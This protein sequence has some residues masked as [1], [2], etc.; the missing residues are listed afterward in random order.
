MNLDTQPLEEIARQIIDL[1]TAE[2]LVLTLPTTLDDTTAARLRA[3]LIGLVPE[4][5]RKGK[6][7][8]VLAHGM[9]LSSI[10]AEQLKALGYQRVQP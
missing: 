4:E 6:A 7:V 2:M 3:E 8:V 9:G 5:H 1:K 10:S